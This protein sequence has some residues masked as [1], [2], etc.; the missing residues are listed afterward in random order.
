MSLNTNCWHGGQTAG[1][2]QITSGVITSAFKRI[3][4][5]GT[6]FLENNAYKNKQTGHFH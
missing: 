6:R 3:P 2:R 1:N 5:S 4:N